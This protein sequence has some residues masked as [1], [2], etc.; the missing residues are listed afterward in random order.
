MK[1]FS[2][3]LS[4]GGGFDWRLYIQIG[5]NTFPVSAATHKDG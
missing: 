5:V 2:V 4:S 1:S 3:A